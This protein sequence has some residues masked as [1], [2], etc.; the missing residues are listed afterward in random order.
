MNFLFKNPRKRI[1]IY[2]FSIMLTH[3]TLYLFFM[4]QLTNALRE[5]KQPLSAGTLKLHRNKNNSY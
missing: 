5:G 2:C 3:G 4:I 1:A